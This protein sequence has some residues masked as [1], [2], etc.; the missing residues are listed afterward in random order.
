MQ[1][2]RGEA[3]LVGLVG[4]FHVCVVCTYTSTSILVIQLCF[5]N[6]FTINSGMLRSAKKDARRI[7]KKMRRNRKIIAYLV[8][9]LPPL[10]AFIIVLCVRTRW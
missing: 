7:E 4:E 9:H 5:S 6:L 10:S 3:E 1:M 8:E 2:R